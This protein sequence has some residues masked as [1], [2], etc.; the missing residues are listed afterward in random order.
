MLTFR[1]PHDNFLKNKHNVYEMSEVLKIICGD[2]EEIC[3]ILKKLNENWKI[4]RFKKIWL[5]NDLIN[6]KIWNQFEL[7]RRQPLRK[8]KTQK[9]A[10]KQLRKRALPWKNGRK[11]KNFART[12]MRLVLFPKVLEK[13]WNSIVKTFHKWLYLIIMLSLSNLPQRI[14]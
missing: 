13:N 12:T 11:F 6:L 9:I 3:I 8:V 10:I 2:L 5:I 4:S 1:L 14:L 7:N